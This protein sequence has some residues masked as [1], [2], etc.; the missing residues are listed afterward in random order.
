[1][2]A[3]GHVLDDIEKSP[4]ESDQGRETAT[5]PRGGRKT[6]VDWLGPQGPRNDIVVSSLDFLFASYILDLE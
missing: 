4:R 3:N 2:R 1:M 6:K 5:D